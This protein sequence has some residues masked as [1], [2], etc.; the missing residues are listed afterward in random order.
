MNSLSYE[1]ALKYDKRTYCQYYWSLL[2]KKQILLF[3][4]FPSN[5]FNLITI[6]ISFF[7]FTF[8]LYCTVN[9]FF[10]TTEI[11][12]KIYEDKEESNFL[13]QLPEIIYSSFIPY[14]IERF[15]KFL[16]LS[17]DAIV[18]I[19]EEKDIEKDFEKA[20]EK[21]K[22]VESCL[23]IKF[24]IYFILSIIFMIFFWCFISCFCAVYT[25]T[26]KMLIKDG[27]SSFLLSMIYPF[28][29][30]LLP[31]L[32]RIPALRAKNKNKKTLYKISLIVAAI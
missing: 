21:S 4:F 9:G 31:G 12:H 16:C 14:L 17:E 1:L 32:F 26:Q 29:I 2:K 10:I 28:I 11:I 22:K 30:N 15:F 8:S 6:K 7:L 13:S 20:K 18:D 24:Y 27:F 3:T 19:K 5:D 23:K 25:N